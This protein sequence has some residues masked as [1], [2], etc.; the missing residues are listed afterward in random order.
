MD[1][2]IKPVGH[3]D[4]PLARATSVV[5]LSEDEDG[6]AVEITAKTAP[7]SSGTLPEELL[8]STLQVSQAR[9]A[10]LLEAVGGSIE[11][12][13]ELHFSHAAAT[14]VEL[15]M[16]TSSSLARDVSPEDE[17]KARA[18]GKGGVLEQAKK[19]Q[20][21]AP[22]SPSAAPLSTF[23]KAG[24]GASS[25]Q[26]KS[27]VAEQP[28]ALQQDAATPA[29]SSTL[30]LKHDEAAAKVGLEDVAAA[31]VP[32]GVLT[33]A[34]AKVAA[35]TKRKEKDAI[36]VEMFTEVLQRAPEDLVPAVYLSSNKLGPPW[37]GLDL[38]VGGSAIT[39]AILS[40]SGAAS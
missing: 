6:E 4:V 2:R 36:L 25:S 16:A 17:R 5:T 19:R 15:P 40:A 32:Y 29:S 14:D 18:H 9:A 21:T 30:L 23:F 13:V 7:G 22:K 1:D 38:G 11:R 37:A 20:K 34:F 28:L 27:A 33:T 10:E 31:A 3:F 39:A 24:T 12:A 26:A 8:A 35:T